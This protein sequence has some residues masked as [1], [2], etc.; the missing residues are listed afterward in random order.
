MSLCA[1][2]FYSPNIY[3]FR[4]SVRCCGYHCIQKAFENQILWHPYILLCNF[5]IAIDE[6]KKQQKKEDRLCEVRLKNQSG[7]NVEKWCRRKE[8]CFSCTW[9]AW[10]SAWR[11][12]DCSWESGGKHGQ[13][14]GRPRYFSMSKKHQDWAS[15]EWDK[16]GNKLKDAMIW[17]AF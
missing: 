5:L 17:P 2:T 9:Y 6:K 4:H 11:P 8:F 7:N 13:S 15:T 1:L 14:S 3:W 10:K 16:N 12:S